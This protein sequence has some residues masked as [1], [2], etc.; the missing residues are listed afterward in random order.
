MT[1]EFHPPDSFDALPWPASSDGAYA[2]RW[3]VPLAEA[4]TTAWVANA[5]V[6]TGV[7]AWPTCVVPVTIT[8]GD[9]G[10]CYVAGP[11]GHFVDYAREELRELHSPALEVALG[12]AIAGLGGVLRA[13]EVNRVAIANNWLLSTNLYPELA[14]E[15]LREAARVLREAFPEH[16]VAFR[17][18]SDVGDRAWAARFREAGFTP[19]PSRQVWW[20]DPAA[21]LPRDARKAWKKD[22]RL[23]EAGPY[24]VVP[25]EALSGEEMTRVRTLYEMLYLGKYSTLNPH[26]TEAF[27]DHA[28]REGLLTFNALR[29][30]DTGRLD[31]V[32]GCFSRNGVLTTPVF[33]YDTALPPEA[34]LYR[35]LSVLVLREAEARGAIAHQSSGAAGFKRSRGARPAI[36]YTMVDVRHLPARRRLAWGML[37]SAMTRVAAPLM[38]RFGV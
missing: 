7:L 15:D 5:D 8:D 35:M 12:L 16:A 28:R 37:A 26:F 22:R 21:A 3:L 10:T 6:R 20:Q 1:P 38:Q 4:G 19:I 18:V 24:E 27:L 36:E 34:G 29:H 9:L 13:G 31:G 23:L 25:G 33:G 2:R 14:V 11:Y 30:R 17:S 32:M